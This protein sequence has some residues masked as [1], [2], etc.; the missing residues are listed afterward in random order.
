MRLAVKLLNFLLLLQPGLADT[1]DQTSATVDRGSFQNPSARLRP[2]FRYWL[3]DS[4][5]NAEI[6]QQNIKAAGAL[7][8][9]GVEFLSFYNYGGQL[10]P[11]PAGSNWS[12]DGFGT[13][14]FHSMFLA[15]LHAHKE[16]GLVMDFPLGPNQG[17][18][19][20]AD[21]SD[22]G[23]QWDLEPF[24][25]AIPGDG[26]F[27][28]EIP[29]WGAG[30]LVA[31]VSAEV[32]QST[33]SSHLQLTL[34]NGTLSDW[35]G[36]VSPSGSVSLD[37]PASQNT[38]R[39]FAF[40]QFLN[41]NKNLQYSSTPA[42]TIFDN[43]SYV[44]DHFTA[45]GAKVTTKFWEEYIL[46]GG[47]KELL[48][49]VGNYG[50]EDSIEILSNIS[51]TPSL[52]STF[53]SKYGYDLKSVLPIIMFS[54]NNINT[55]STQPGAIECL[56]NTPD[57]GLG[58]INDFRG[59]LVDGYRS[60]LE[61]LTR[62]VNLELNLQMS[63]QVSYNL[64]M[65]MESNIPFVN[66]PECESLQFK[67]SIDGYRQFT[68]PA[69]LAGK[70]VISNEMGAVMMK[71]YQLTHSELLYSINRAVVGGVN[72]MVFHGQTY[73]GEYYGTTWPGYTA[74]LY[75]FSEMYSDKQ[76]SW[77]HG[78]GDLLNYTARVQYLQQSGVP[79]TDVAI[80]NKVSGT[81][82]NFPTLYTA[83]DLI[84]AG[85]TY[86]YL[87][88]DNFA[89]PEANVRDGTLAPNGPAYKA[90]VI[91][92]NSNLTL[93][94]V[95]Y[96]QKY[97][98]AGLPVILA[99]GDPGV[100]ASHDNRD[101]KS[102]RKAIQALKK[103]ANVCSVSAGQVSA[104]L[105]ALGLRPQVATHT[106]GT[107]YTTWRENSQTGLDHAFVF[108]D[109]NASTGTLDIS[110]RK[111]PFLFDPWT[112]SKKPL[113]GYTQ[114]KNRVTIPLSLAGNQTIIVGF[115][116][117][118]DVST[119]HAT[120]IPSSVIGY[121]TQGNA[122]VSASKSQ[123]TLVLSNGKKVILPSPKVASS[124][125]LS[126]WT[127]TAEHWEA[128]S[129]ISDASTIAIKHNTT[130]QLSSLVSWHQIEGLTNSSG[131]GYYT[132]HIT[133]PPVKG[134]ADGAY[135]FLP[136]IDHTARVYVNGHQLPPLDLT[137]PR[138]DL[139]T[140]LKKGSNAL[141]VIVPTTMWNYIRSIAD[142]IETVNVPIDSLMDAAG[143]GLPQAT[144]N[145]LIGEVKLVPYVA[146][147]L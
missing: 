16:A 108:C 13:E 95:H 52:P 111:T 28:G 74:F 34:K 51:W 99:G 146:V 115:G 63:A 69:H 147:K 141:A 101:N 56:L 44:V 144:D 30:E 97:A 88:P 102:I 124:S 122:V 39:L 120:N 21:P 8:A 7:G 17:Q 25:V 76:P 35:A 37:L 20:P 67:D 114:S 71:A 133:W 40:Y 5:V 43:G 118:E 131:L 83:N 87:S 90:L 113:L 50:W 103:S 104:K 140:Y 85:Y 59:A 46:P 4:G 3:P 78:F 143:Y 116:E 53:H 128:P 112:G 61:E 55:Q 109:V 26:H 91:T 33:N 142:E 92:S 23:L 130:H 86:S 138:A 49:E 38:Y 32:L 137:A 139:S 81:N 42:K 1:N 45:R 73:T 6:V 89:L 65:D 31:L 123:Q 64:P 134:S 107:W 132:T 75:L 126:N 129:N 18:G 119:K 84:D 29:G 70:R 136:P 106:N 48:M 94:G 60:Y 14:A 79:R 77:D 72:Q 2:R 15:A 125:A 54:N 22:E 11:A 57:H 93:S 27:D 98:Q 9:G 62:W 19:V 47:V 12:R 145:G 96:I 82:P 58:Y 41:H 121:D 66:A 127:L 24:S 105:H 36:K 135:L 80:Y 100:Y 110:T 117:N 68:G 10:A